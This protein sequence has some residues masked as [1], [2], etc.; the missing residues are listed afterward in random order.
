M[1]KTFQINRGKEKISGTR[2]LIY[3]KNVCHHFLPSSTALTKHTGFRTQNVVLRHG[4]SSTGSAC[5]VWSLHS[6]PAFFLR[7]G[8]GPFFC[9]QSKT[10][11][12]SNDSSQITKTI[13]SKETGATIDMNLSK[14]PISAHLYV[15]FTMGV[16][17]GKYIL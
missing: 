3:S 14:T 13:H 7:Q 11:L 12:R 4:D 5:M 1:N 9:M 17:N 2:N 10:K 15:H 16:S 6:L 8:R